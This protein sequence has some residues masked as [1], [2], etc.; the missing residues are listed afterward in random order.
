M[1]TFVMYG[2]IYKENIVY[3]SLTSLFLFSVTRAE[4]DQAGPG[5]ARLGL[6]SLLSGLTRRASDLY[7]PILN[8]LWELQPVLTDPSA[9][10][11]WIPTIFCFISPLRP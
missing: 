10:T 8:D 1:L 2:Q 4:A 7:T 5:W 3:S 9:V 11:D 6:P